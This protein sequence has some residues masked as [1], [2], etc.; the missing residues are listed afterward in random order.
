MQFKLYPV[1]VLLLLSTTLNA[2]LGLFS[3]NG[4]HTADPKDIVTR[5]TKLKLDRSILKTLYA[6]KPAELRLA[7]PIENETIIIK[8]KSAQLFRKNFEVI[9]SS[10]LETY[11]YIPGYYLQG[12]VE[13][14]EHSMAAISIFDDFAGG[15]IS[16]KGD[17]YNLVIANN[18]NDHTSDDYLVYADRNF[19]GQRPKCF[20]EDDKASIS[21]DPG[22][23]RSAAIVGCP[24][25]IYFET[26]YEMLE[27][28]G[29]V[30]QVMN[31]L[32]ILFN[33]EQ[34]IYFNED[35]IMQI[36]EIKVW[37]TAEPEYSLTT[38]S[39][40][41]SSFV[42]RMLAG[43]NGDLAHYVTFNNL[44]GG[45]AWLNVL[46]AAP[47][48]QTGVSG[49]LS[50]SYSPY[51]NYSFSV[52]V[53]THEMGHNFGS[54]HTH[55]CTWPGGAIDDCYA[56]EGTC[57]PGPTPVG[58]GT[59]MSYCHLDWSI[60]VNLANGFG[61]LPGNLLRTKVT[62]ASNNGCIC[63][64]DDIQLD[65]TKQDIGCGNPLGSANAVVTGGTG[66]FTYL[67][68]NGAV[69]SSVTGLSVGTYYVTVTGASPNCTVIKGF[70]I[71]SSGNLTT[72][73]LSP[74]ATSATKCLNDTYTVSATIVPS[75]SYTYQW[76]QNNIAIPGATSTSIAITSAVANVSAYHLVANGGTCIG[77]S[78]DITVD[79]QAITT[80][81]I[82]VNGSAAICENESV[83]L[84]I[85]ASSAFSTEWRLSGTPI[86]GATN[87]TYTV[88]APGTYT[89]RRYSP[90][91]AGC[92][93]ISAAV[94]ITSKPKPN[95]ATN[96][97][98]LAFCTGEQDVI[99][100]SQ[101]SGETYEWYKNNVLIPGATGNDLSV[102]SAG[103]YY[104]QVTGTNGCKN[105]STVTTVIVNPLP[106]VT[107][108]P[109]N[110]VTLC[111]GGTL[112]LNA[113]ALSGAQYTWFDGTSQL[114]SG[115]ANTLNVTH[116]GSYS[117]SIKNTVTGCMKSSVPTQ[118]T[119]IPPPVI[120]AGNDTVLATGQP[121]RLHVSEISS[122]GID[123]YE[124]TPSTGLDNPFSNSPVA[125][126]WDEQEY[127][128][129]GV[130]PSGCV[131]TDKVLIKVYPGP[132]IYVPSAFSPN[133][134]S[135]NDLL[136]CIAVGLKSFKYFKIFNRFGQTIFYTTNP[137]TGWDGTWSGRK[138]DVGTYVY[139]AEGVD[140]KGKPIIAKGTVTILF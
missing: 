7:I 98:S 50:A 32:T 80:P 92:S 23:A 81:V 75:G 102:N 67:W 124:W 1:L 51:P 114:S 126:L 26:G 110:T 86:A 15:V 70:K 100:H 134:D 34:L 128:V 111:D 122:L 9:L 130:H 129:K 97:T 82:T 17:N 84:S 43:F 112:T 19:R 88:T 107:L 121:Y 116:S 22:S 72:V 13:G 24:V 56:V 8:L 52:N 118:V 90:T 35:I 78:P 41:L 39:A 49:N 38:T 104:L 109:A 53:I 125:I 115:A 6:E 5:A 33:A 28:Q 77:Q 62:D 73:S 36:R 95:A 106:A 132:A 69:T 68:S 25:D 113:S 63:E 93:V 57:S 45:R 131:A 85:P 133:G 18:S 139:I 136:K 47:Q 94:T 71:L 108:S 99:S 127:I 91:S 12:T 37:N 31:Y 83:Q 89:V 40:A 16:Y 30:Q 138:L 46:C 21:I 2:Q 119:I 103:N 10:T 3:Y 66:P 96:T 20:T 135:K 137:S 65:V 87:A 105:K 44:G 140:Y 4:I 64:C 123:H 74:S 48:S 59:V 11:S 60:G 27:S 79:F 55:S 61:P 120:F 14:E 58:G 29:T 101:L 54:P 117:V 42:S 76:Y